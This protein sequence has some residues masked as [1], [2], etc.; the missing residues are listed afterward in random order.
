V[1]I[2]L[3]APLVSPIREPQIGGVATLLTDLA[4]GLQDAGYEVDLFAASGSTYPGLHLI[5]TGIDAGD[6]AETLFRPLEGPVPADV[7]ERR[8]ARAA[9]AFAE[10]Y[11]RIAAGR[12]DVVHNHA[13]DAPA[14]DAAIALE[15][16]V[17][18]TLHLPPEPAVAAALGRAARAPRPPV[19]AA[20]SPTQRAGWR[21]AARIDVLLPA[22][23][24][25]A[26]IPWSAVGGSRLVVAGR[27]SPEKGV[28]E[29]IEIAGRVG[30]E[31]VIAGVRY[32]PA[33]AAQ[34]D[35]AAARAGGVRLAGAL[36]RVDLW[37]LL[38]GS[39][40][41]LFP[42]RWEEPFGMV[43]AEAQA[44]GCPV[45]GFGRGALPDVIDDGFTGA[46]LAPGDVEGAVEAVDRLDE[47]D[48]GACRRHAEAHLDTARMIAAHDALYRRLHS[49]R[50][51]TW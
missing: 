21:A 43:A 33:Y 48:R 37:R 51:P 30:R 17:V 44:T 31:L 20:V 3:L 23:V 39:A 10:A 27:L 47:F 24:P 46:V 5:D 14:I 9:A 40:A 36:P 25:T 2:A 28:L 18:H 34:V 38:A 4:A 32:D 41:L 19:V 6:M 45:I 7:R 15:A 16:P 42:I 13:F 35:A 12:Y 50:P 11:G 26:R 49:A 8:T 1:R 29:A 22:G